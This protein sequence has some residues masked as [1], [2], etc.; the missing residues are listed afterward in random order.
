[1]NAGQPRGGWRRVLNGRMERPSF[2]LQPERVGSWGVG[3]H[4]PPG[5]SH[6]SIHILA[7]EVVPQLPGPGEL[8]KVMQGQ[9]SLGP[10]PRVRGTKTGAVLFISLPYV[11][12]R[13]SV[14][15]AAGK[16]APTELLDCPVCHGPSICE[17]YDICKRNKAKHHKTRSAGAWCTVKAQ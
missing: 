9:G 3:T 8:S 13:H 14:S 6:P 16:M 11:T 15:R 7:Y 1:M 12:Q 4:S 10:G 2:Y 17:K 5:S